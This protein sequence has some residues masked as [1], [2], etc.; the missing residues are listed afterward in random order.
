M[1][2]ADSLGRTRRARGVHDVGQVVRGCSA[3]GVLGALPSDGVPI[4]V[5]SHDMSR[6]AEWGAGPSYIAQP[7]GG[8]QHR[9]PRIFQHVRQSFLGVVGIERHVDAACLENG[10]E[11][12]D[13][14]ER[15][16]HADR[17]PRLRSDPEGS[18]V[19]RETVCALIELAVGQ[20]LVSTDHRDRVGSPLHLGLVELVDASI[21]R[22][23]HGGVVP[24]LEQLTPL[25]LRSRAATARSVHPGSR[26]R[27]RAAAENARS[28][29]RWCRGRRDRCCSRCSPAA[30][31]RPPS[32][33]GAS[34]TAMFSDRPPPPWR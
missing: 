30:P 32:S 31:P 2:H 15:A 16:L 23:R 21:A 28:G 1:R 3:D 10:Q 4:R 22:I 11:T 17:H 8:Q 18:E 5:Q 20:A 7:L 6:R 27:A 26:R 24:L 34:R 25:R 29:G 9:H 19:V 13:H 14:L 12:N 33:T